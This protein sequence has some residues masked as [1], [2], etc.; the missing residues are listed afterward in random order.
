[1][2]LLDDAAGDIPVRLKL[3]S[4]PKVPR[5]DRGQ[6][7]LNSFYSGIDELWNSRFDAVI[8]TGT[9]PASA[10]LRRGTLLARAGR[11]S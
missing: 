1:M 3:Y 2:E 6:Q 11:C 5:G 7:H 9:E 8:M 4:L 10:D